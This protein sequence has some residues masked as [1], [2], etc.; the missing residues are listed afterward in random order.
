MKTVKTVQMSAAKKLNL[1]EDPRFLDITVKSGDKYFAPTWAMVQAYK[2]GEI[3]EEE[4]SSIYLCLLAVR[5]Q[6]DDTRWKQ[7][8]EMDEVWLACYCR[9]GDFCHR[10]LLKDQLLL[11]GFADGGEMH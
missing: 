8:L 7:L 1:F 3:S 11:R 4:Y 5:R 2:A 9:A 6:K 10:L